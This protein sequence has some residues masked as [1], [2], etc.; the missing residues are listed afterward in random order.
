MPHDS[1]TGD[2]T[3]SGDKSDKSND[4]TKTHRGSPVPQ[5]PDVSDPSGGPVSHVGDYNPDQDLL[6]FGSQFDGNPNAAHYHGLSVPPFHG[7]V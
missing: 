6:G 1:S 5:P 3:K 4:S 7:T 2:N